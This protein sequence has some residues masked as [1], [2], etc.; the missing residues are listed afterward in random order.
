MQFDPTQA[1]QVIQNARLPQWALPH[2]W[3]SLEGQVHLANLHMEHGKI[4]LIAPSTQPQET[5]HSPQSLDLEGA[6][7]LPSLVD[8]HT[9]LDKTLTLSRMGPVGPG[10]LNAIQAMMQDRAAWT[11]DD[12]EKRASQALRMALSAGVTHIRSHCDCW[13]PHQMPLAWS[14]LEA[15]SQ[16]WQ[17]KIRLERVALI[18]LTLFKNRNDA[19][20]LAQ[21]VKASQLRVPGAMLGGFIHSSNWDPEALENLLLA[22]QNHE[23]DL[24]LHVDEELNPNAMGL[25]TIAERV[26]DMGFAG[27]VVC[28]HTCALSQMPEHESLKI[29]DQVAK[30]GITLI[31]LPI[32]NLFLQD[33]QTQ[34]TPRIRGMTLIKEARERK[35][36]VLLASD[37]VQDPFCAMG[38]Y[39]PLEAFSVGVP[40]GQL[41]SAFDQWTELLC[42]PEW[43]HS[44]ISPPDYSPF[45][46]GARADFV[47]F[48]QANATGF[49]SQSHARQIIRAGFLSSPGDQTT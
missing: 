1:L 41:N 19:L 15:L 36:P 23:L 14:V 48:T 10:L 37:N 13:E 7:L 24:D 2:S 29:L 46:V 4:T 27:R 47:C 20:F 28:A 3:P 49:P 25:K 5:R 43:I 45:G 12:V 39:D 33:A 44:K 21:S 6:L 30:A 35:I 34:R 9:H 17:E 16:T 26:H 22:A 18:P 38:S 42:R 8:A 11:P 32:T 40:M 31:T